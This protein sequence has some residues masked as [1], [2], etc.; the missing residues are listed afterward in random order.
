MRDQIT[1]PQFT[2]EAFLVIARTFKDLTNRNK[3][4]I[5]AKTIIRDNR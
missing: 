5:N 1:H 2:V 3:Q 4:N